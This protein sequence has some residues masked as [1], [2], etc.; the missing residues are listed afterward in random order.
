MAIIVFDLT[1]YH[2]L[3][4]VDFWVDEINKSNAYDYFIVLVGNKSDLRRQR[5]VSYE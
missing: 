4:C 5:K 3:E 1:N 2:S